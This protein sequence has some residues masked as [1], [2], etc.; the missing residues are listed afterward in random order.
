MSLYKKLTCQ[1]TLRQVFYLFEAP[2][3]PMILIPYSPPPH[4][5][6][7]RVYLFTQEGGGGR[8][9]QRKI[10][11]AIVHKASRKYKYT[12]KNAV[13]LLGAFRP[14]VEKIQYH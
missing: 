3:S 10:R 9:N 5:H 14:D 11:L 7:I 8:A 2:Y 12:V 4:T 6:C 1:G 13:E